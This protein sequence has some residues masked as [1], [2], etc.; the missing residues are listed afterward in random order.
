LKRVFVD[1][2]PFVHDNKNNC[3]ID[4]GKLSFLQEGARVKSANTVYRPNCLRGYQGS[5][6]YCDSSTYVPTCMG[7]HDF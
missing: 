4:H 2:K 1:E 7:H 3:N 5:L 6:L